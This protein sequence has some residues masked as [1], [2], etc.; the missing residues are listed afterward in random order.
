M[1]SSILL[2][3]AF[4]D[5]VCAIYRGRALLVLAWRSTPTINGIRNM[6]QLLFSSVRGT[7]S[8]TLVCAL[9]DTE[10]PMPDAATREALQVSIQRLGLLRGA[11]N[12]IS[13]RGF[14]AAAMRGMLSGFA[15]VVRPKYPTSFVSSAAEAASFVVTT[16]HPGTRRSRRGATLPARSRP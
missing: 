14:G 11:V 2:E 8:S 1:S 9:V 4:S 10:M 3:Q 7:V 13:G 12:V 5:D 6:S 15:L 16:G